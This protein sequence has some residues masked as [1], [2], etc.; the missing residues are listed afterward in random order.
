MNVCQRFGRRVIGGLVFFGCILLFLIIT[1]PGFAVQEGTGSSFQDRP[2]PPPGNFEENSGNIPGTGDLVIR[3]VITL[4]ILGT[5]GWAV[6]RFWKRGGDSAYNGSWLSLVDQVSL[7]PNKNI[8]ITEIAG[9]VFVI[10]VTDHSIQPIMEI[11]DATLI[12]QIRTTK[13]KKTEKFS[14]PGFSS[15][16]R[17]LNNHFEFDGSNKREHSFH[18][19]MRRQLERLDTIRTGESRKIDGKREGEEWL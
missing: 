13:S 3:L 16:F 15:L 18:D 11:T 10:G 7:G 19:E 17:G 8:Y 9:R 14:I 12:E 5:A 1:I 2:Y 6:V 4:G